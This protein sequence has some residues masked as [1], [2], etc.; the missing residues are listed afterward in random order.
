MN[1]CMNLLNGLF[2]V[3]LP[4]ILIQK[5]GNYKKDFSHCI[6]T[7]IFI[8]KRTKALIVRLSKSKLHTD[9]YFFG[10]LLAFLPHR[11]ES[12]ILMIVDDPFFTAKDA[13]LHKYDN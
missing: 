3:I 11:N 2:N 9:E 5:V 13:F 6:P 7:I 10:L 4:N 1:D 8:R 12:D